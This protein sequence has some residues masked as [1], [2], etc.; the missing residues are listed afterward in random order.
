M[1]FIALPVAGQSRWLHL[2]S[3]PCRFW[4]STGSQFQLD[5]PDSRTLSRLNV[6]HAHRSNT[7]RH[8]T[9]MCCWSDVRYIYEVTRIGL[10]FRIES[11][12]N[13]SGAQND[14][15]QLCT[16]CN[17]ESV[18][19]SVFLWSTWLDTSCEFIRS[20]VVTPQNKHQFEHSILTTVIQQ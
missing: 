16:I 14:W 17:M 15:F 20:S 13:G 12:I 5:R 4:R 9:R 19:V 3:Q 1:R 11:L 10:A 8:S 7:H 2:I 6:W 18:S